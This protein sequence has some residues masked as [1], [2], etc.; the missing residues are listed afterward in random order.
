MK[1]DFCS[2]NFP[3]IEGKSEYQV[4]YAEKLRRKYVN[5]KLNFFERVH[6]I[7]EEDNDK[8]IVCE[9]ENTEFER[10]L[11]GIQFTD[12]DR[13]VLFSKNAGLIISAVSKW[14][15]DGNKTNH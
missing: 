9:A 7:S 15:A 5:N 3:E 11:N 10:K 8:R 14:I 2:I 13:A 6:R 1:Y 4:E 12:C